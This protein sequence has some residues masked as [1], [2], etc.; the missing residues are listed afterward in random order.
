[1]L[2]ILIITEKEFLDEAKR[3]GGDD[4]RDFQTYVNDVL[5]GLQSSCNVVSIIPNDKH[6]SFVVTFKMY[7]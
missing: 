1:M 7:K 5:Y 2:Q 3:S 4:E 6:T